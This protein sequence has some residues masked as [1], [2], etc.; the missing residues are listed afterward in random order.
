VKKE[1]LKVFQ[2]AAVF[3]GTIV[4]AGLASGKEITQFFTSYGYKSFIGIIFCGL[5]YIAMCSIM[6][7]ISISFN[8][9]SYGEVINV[10]SPNFLGKITGTIT[11]LYLIS[12]ASIILAG[13]GALLNQFFG[14]PKILGT[15]IMATAALLAL[16]RETSGLIEVN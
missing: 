4:G 11:T 16:T 8:L 10:V 14:I 5:F 9:S 6:A 13:S 1:A 12:S 15:L 7:K 3:I 2:I